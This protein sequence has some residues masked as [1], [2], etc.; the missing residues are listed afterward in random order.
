[1]G[2]HGKKGIRACSKMNPHNS[3]LFGAKSK[4]ILWRQ[5]LR[6]IGMLMIENATTKK[7]FF[8][9]FGSA[10]PFPFPLLLHPSSP[11]LAPPC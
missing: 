1:V 5:S 2:K 3:L 6:K 7:I 10:H 4:G 8:F 9:P 11:L